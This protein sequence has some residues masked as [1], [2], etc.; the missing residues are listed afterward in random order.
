MKEEI[1]KI[2]SETLEV[3]IVDDISPMY[4]DSLDVIDLV[5]K[6]ED[7]YSIKINIRDLKRD[8][9]LNELSVFISNLID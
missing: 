7:T 1:R 4:L 5:I 8:I 9:S 2:I 6:L 3:D